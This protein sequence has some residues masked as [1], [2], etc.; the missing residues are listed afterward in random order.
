MVTSTHLRL[1]TVITGGSAVALAMAGTGLDTVTVACA[2]S[3]AAFGSQAE[4][5]VAVLVMIVPSGTVQATR[6]ETITCALDAISARVQE[7]VPFAPTGGVVHVHPAADTDSNVIGAG[8]GSATAT[9]SAT[10][11][12]A[13]VAV[14]V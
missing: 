12:P 3:F 13:S 10:S 4:V 8:S 2:A 9:C 14:T 6:A 5:A 11:G 7:T 1:G